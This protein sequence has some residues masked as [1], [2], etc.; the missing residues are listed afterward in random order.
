MMRGFAILSIALSLGFSWTQTPSTPK[1]PLTTPDQEQRLAALLAKADGPYTKVATGVWT[2]AYRGKQMSSITVRVAAAQDGVFFFVH[3]FDRKSTTFSRNALL[4]IAEFNSDFDYGKL[5][6]SDSAL[7]IR[8]DVRAKLLDLSELKF[9]ES[10]AA[11]MADEA[12]G[13]IR[14]YVQ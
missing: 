13:L 8:I 3:L 10:Q 2:T 11:A 6:L 1:P 9:Y 7:E 5:A 14:D 12:Y 4:K